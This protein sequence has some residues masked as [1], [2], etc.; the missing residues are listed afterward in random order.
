MLDIYKTFYNFRA[1]P[2]RLSPDYTFSFAHRSYAHA[3]AY[4]TYAISQGEGCIAIT[5]APGTGKTTLIR[6]A[7]SE[8]RDVRFQVGMLTSV[9]L[10]PR[11]FLRMVLNAFGLRL[12]EGTEASP[13]LQ[14]QQFLLE[15]SQRGRQTVLIVDEAQGLSASSLEKLRLLSNIQSNNQLLLQVFLVGQEQLLEMLHAPGME[16]LR[17]RLVAASR[18]D[19]LD[20]DETVSYVEHRLCQVGWKGIPKISEGV[21]RAIYGFSGGVPRSINLICNRLLILGGLEQK[22]ELGS[23][24]ARQV[25]DELLEEGLLGLV[26]P[27]DA[28]VY[29]D[30]E[31]QS[32]DNVTTPVRSLPRGQSCVKAEQSP[33]MMDDFQEPAAD[34]STRIELAPKV[35]NDNRVF[36]DKPGGL[37]VDHLGLADE[38]KKALATYTESGGIGKTVL[39]QAEAVAVMQ[40]KYEIC[41]GL[42]HSFD[43]SKW[44]TGTPKDRLLLLPAAQE[45]ILSQDD[46]K[47]RLLRAVT[48]LS[49]AFTLSMPHEEALEIRDD[50]GFFQAV[51]A[52]L[53]K[54]TP[55]ERKTDEEPEHAIWQSI[56][57]AVVSDEVVDKCHT[58]SADGP[59]GNDLRMAPVCQ[60]ALSD[61]TIDDTDRPAKLAVVMDSET[62]QDRSP[63][64]SSN[65]KPK[66]ATR[67]VWM[68]AFGLPSALGLVASLDTEIDDQMVEFVHVLTT[69]IDIDAR[70]TGRATDDHNRIAPEPAA[71]SLREQ[72]HPTTR[73]TAGSH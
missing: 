62:S 63:A 42:F 52:V 4:L 7:V 1:E 33:S 56:S 60:D 50:L 47:V 49:Q 12:D 40:E 67:W 30:V 72:L 36:K 9:Q 2:F 65:K 45:H 19:P 6:E 17:Q 10:D 29:K 20:L 21:L 53:A 54:C 55:G 15:Q 22:R 26:V 24:D 32:D 59:S 27:M 5:G 39:D 43:W 70:M 61:M 18:L 48:D 34:V 68:A 41:R 35:P 8:L 44:T 3:K 46:G 11:N 37:V 73:R 64:E 69:G 66:N 28:E 25:I 13:L 38:L 58:P 57:K 16:H 51:R 23:E 14:L 31:A 71:A